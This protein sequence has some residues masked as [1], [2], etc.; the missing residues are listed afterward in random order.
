M[1]AD[2]L[3]NYSGVIGT[4]ILGLASWFL[5]KYFGIKI[6]F[7]KAKPITSALTPVVVPQG[8]Y[9]EAELIEVEESHLT[10]DC[11][12][13]LRA[14]LLTNG[15]IVE[16]DTLASMLPSLLGGPANGAK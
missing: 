4:A 9:N 11:Y 5:L 2:L 7:S 6:D 14:I 13:H 15:H 8:I 12:Q 1:L 3:Q 16:A 10:V